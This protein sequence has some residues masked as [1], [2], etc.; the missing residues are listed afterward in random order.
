[1]D[2]WK[3]GILSIRSFLL[4]CP[5]YHLFIRVAD[6]WPKCH[7]VACLLLKR[8]RLNPFTVFIHVHFQTLFQ[9]ARSALVPVSLVD[10]TATLHGRTQRERE[11]KGIKLLQPSGVF[12]ATR[13]TV[14]GLLSCQEVSPQVKDCVVIP[15]WSTCS[16]A[17]P[18]K[19]HSRPQVFYPAGCCE[20]SRLQSH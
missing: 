13:A 10:R 9:T 18:V 16:P 15:E 6:F 20:N 4:F 12:Y 3:A 11:K 17:A 7:H 5:H 19:P 1:M 8:Y 2:Y 14:F